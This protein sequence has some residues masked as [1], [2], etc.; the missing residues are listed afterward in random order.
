MAQ[1]RSLAERERLLQE[2]RCMAPRCRQD[3]KNGDG[4]QFLE[5]DG[6]YS[7]FCKRCASNRMQ[8]AQAIDVCESIPAIQ[9]T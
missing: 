1:G 7:R 9:S 2:G 5:E 4:S 6:T 8:G 3:V